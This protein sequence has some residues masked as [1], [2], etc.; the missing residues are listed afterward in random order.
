MVNGTRTQLESGAT[1]ESPSGRWS[2]VAGS[3]LV[4]VIVEW[5]GSAGYA[6]VVDRDSDWRLETGFTRDGKFR[7]AVE[8]LLA[9]FAAAAVPPVVAFNANDVMTIGVR[10]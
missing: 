7:E 2:A 8:D 3:E 1:R 6:V 10:R 5:G 9:G 4:R